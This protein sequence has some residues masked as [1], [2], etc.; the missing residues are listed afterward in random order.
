M[1]GGVNWGVCYN[2]LYLF[3]T[4]LCAYNVLFQSKERKNIDIG[5]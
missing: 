5:I 3:N 2:S 4:K 1:L